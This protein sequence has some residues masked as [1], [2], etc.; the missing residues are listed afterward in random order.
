METI[1]LASASPRRQELLKLAG[2]PFIA[3]PSRV[4]E[5]LHDD[6]HPAEAAK[7]LAHQKLEVF[8]AN[9]RSAGCHWALAA[10]T[11]VHIDGKNLGKPADREQA[12][13]YLR[14]LSGREHIVYTGMVLFSSKS[15]RRLDWVEQ[16][17]VLMSELNSQDLEWYLDSGEWQDAAGAYKIQ[18]KSQ[19]LVQR[20]SGSYSNIMGL[21]L[22]PLYRMLQ[23]LDYSVN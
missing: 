11:F 15:G 12:E 17:H 9:A 18:G 23:E 20:I 10:D 1:I 4:V 14:L 8:L 19:C 3:A 7:R 5:I 21:P 16:S 6:E 22:Q 13:S 2:F